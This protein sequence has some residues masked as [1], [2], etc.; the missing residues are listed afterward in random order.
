[1]QDDLQRAFE[2]LYDLTPEQIVSM[3]ADRQQAIAQMTALGAR[4]DPQALD[5]LLTYM[6]QTVN[7]LLRPLA[8]IRL[9]EIGDLS[10][11]HQLIPMV[12]DE[13]ANDRDL[14]LLAV[15]VLGDLRAESAFRVLVHGLQNDDDGEVR[16]R[17]AW[18]LGRL[19]DARALIALAGAM[20]QSQDRRLRHYAIEAIGRVGDAS[21]TPLMKRIA[22]KHPD[23]ETRTYAIEALGRFGDAD[24]VDTL[25]SLLDDDEES[26]L[27]RSEAA[28]ALGEAGDARAIP[29][30]QRACHNTHEWVQHHAR[31]SLER[32]GAS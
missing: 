3:E 28:A 32:L 14:R 17:C 1:M 16:A 2:L 4:T 10:I 21:L 26:P 30:L 29:S 31:K 27:L 5:I 25:L 24:A 6:R 19:G 13:E 18:A 12:E 11:A 22:Q 9:M 8:A 7:R 23:K 15:Q 20:R